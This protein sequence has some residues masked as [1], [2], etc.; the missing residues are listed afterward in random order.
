MT[1]DKSILPIINCLGTA[2]RLLLLPH[3]D[4]QSAKI[5]KKQLANMWTS[6]V[7]S[8]TILFPYV[9]ILV[10]ADNKS[11]RFLKE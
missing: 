9:N 1:G 7:A 6:N 2:L 4:Y 5:A 11:N 3:G 10:F 8:L